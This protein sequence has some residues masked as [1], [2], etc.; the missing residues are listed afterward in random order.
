MTSQETG[1]LHIYFVKHNGCRFG[2]VKARADSK[3]QYIIYPKYV[4]SASHNIDEARNE[5]KA[6]SEHIRSKRFV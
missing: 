1:R 6:N 3:G 2:T 4:C 5:P